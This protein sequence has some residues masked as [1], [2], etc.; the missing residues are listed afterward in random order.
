L[1]R[2]LSGWDYAFCSRIAVLTVLFVVQIRDLRAAVP[3]RHL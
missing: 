1:G 2:A 3:W